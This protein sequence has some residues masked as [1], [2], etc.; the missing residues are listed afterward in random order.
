M[1]RCSWAVCSG[2]EEILE[3]CGE[4]NKPNIVRN[5]SRMMYSDLCILFFKFDFNSCF[6]YGL[7]LFFFSLP[8]QAPSCAMSC[9]CFCLSFFLFLNLEARPSLLP[10]PGL[11]RRW[12]TSLPGYLSCTCCI[13]HWTPGLHSAK[14]DLLPQLW[15]GPS[16]LEEGTW[17]T[18]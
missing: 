1:T 14:K 7:C 16:Q 15:P 17:R 4:A 9:V 8:M 10:A 18:G 3:G 6:F 5:K 12:H 11:S 13:P 2:A